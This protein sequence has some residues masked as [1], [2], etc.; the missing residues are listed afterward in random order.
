MFTRIVA[1]LVV[2]LLASS[3]VLAQPSTR[4][5]T[6]DGTAGGW[7]AINKGESP[8]RT[9]VGG[10]VSL[11]ASGLTSG[12]API[13]SV[14]KG[15]GKLP[16]DH[17]QIW[18]E[19]DISP[20]TLRVTTTEHPQKA[21]IDWILRDTGTEIW[22]SEPLGILSATRNTLYVYHT[23]EMHGLIA[24]VVDRFLVDCIDGREAESYAFSLRLI[25]IASPNWRTTAMSLL[26]PV[27]VKAAGVDAWLLSKENAAVLIGQLQKRTDF[28][29]LNSPNVLINNGQSHTI[30]RTTPRNYVRSVRMRPDVWPG[31]ELNMGQILEGYS[32][33]ISPLMTVDGN[34]IDA[35]V[36]CHIDQVEKLVP[37]PVDV[38]SPSGG[39][40]RVQIQVPQVVSWRLHE[41]FRWPASQVMLLGCGVVASPT[42]ERSGPLGLPIPS[43]P[44]IPLTNSPNR[45]DALLFIEC[46][47]KQSQTLLEAKRD[48]RDGQPNFNGR[49]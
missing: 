7:Q 39:A 34:T 22:F 31:H 3:I 29:E 30:A 37:V 45:A 26:Q 48:L 47:G 32:L 17:G 2:M 6:G 44:G 10:G 25:T 15:S 41:R 40:Q 19:Y 18:R 36:R 4:L 35:V 42:A 24:D 46:K 43:V 27:D 9:S 12:S 1:P 14:S 5:P 13:T 23:E 11:A 8:L 38:P 49:Y 21:V 33:Q 20:Y 16:N 28:R